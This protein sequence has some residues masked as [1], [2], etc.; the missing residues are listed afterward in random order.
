MVVCPE[1]IHY[2][3]IIDCGVAPEAPGYR[4][5]M[6]A[7]KRFTCLLERCDHQWAAFAPTDGP[8]PLHLQSV[9]IGLWTLK[10]RKKRGHEIG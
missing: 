4:Q 2:N 8:M 10:L 7:E 5:L 1:S 9:L 6:V 3:S